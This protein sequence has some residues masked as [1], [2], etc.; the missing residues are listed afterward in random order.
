MKN[1]FK[2][3]KFNFTKLRTN[4][5]KP[6]HFQDHYPVMWREVL[7]VVKENI[8]FEDTKPKLFGDFTIGCGGHTKLILDTFQNAHVVGVDLDKKMVEHSAVKLAQYIVDR[9]L[10]I[11]HDN[12]TSIRDIDILESFH[13]KRIFSSSK[14][15]DM[16]LVDLGYNSKQ[17]DDNSKGISFKS[18]DSELDMRYDTDNNDIA[19]ASDILNN[20]TELELLETFK[21]FGEEKHAEALIA[22]IVKFRDTQKFNKVGDFIDVIDRTYKAKSKDIFDYYTRLF[23]ALRIGVNYELFNLRRFLGKCL[24]CLEKNG[25]IAVITFHSGEDNIVKTLFNTSEKIG[26]CK[27]LYKQ[28]I[29]P[30][31]IELGENSRSKS[32]TLRVLKYIA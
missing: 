29:R 24:T 26:V 11:F 3:G 27:V 28:G 2:Y 7:D 22:N 19:K 23:Q 6:I 1:I 13:E 10:V 12:Y 9:R 8:Y 25:I 21:S 16:L 17:L 20:C 32:A 4:E 31:K 5:Y 14:K 18:R 15:F 30:S